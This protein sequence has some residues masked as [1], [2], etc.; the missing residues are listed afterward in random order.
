MSQITGISAL[1]SLMLGAVAMLL[2]IPL[3]YFIALAIGSRVASSISP[4]TSICA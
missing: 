4:A 2:A 3:S 1:E